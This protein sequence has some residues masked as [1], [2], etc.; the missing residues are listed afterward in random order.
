[1]HS[2]LVIV[3]EHGPKVQAALPCINCML[4]YPAMSRLSL[5]LA[6]LCLKTGL[7]LNIQLLWESMW[8]LPVCVACRGR[9]CARAGVRG[10]VCAR[11][12]LFKAHG[13]ELGEGVVRVC[14]FVCLVCCC[15]V[16]A[17]LVSCRCA[18]SLLT[19]S[20]SS[21]VPCVRAPEQQR[22][23]ALRANSSLRACSLSSVHAY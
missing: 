11:L 2:K 17:V 3:C 10:R 14:V 4:F 9:V 20:W 8:Q 15:F 12:R 19:C 21:A 13:G 6:A 5:T 22:V 7:K 18:C 16:A 1:M 23:R